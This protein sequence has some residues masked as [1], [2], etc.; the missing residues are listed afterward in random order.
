VDATLNKVPPLSL[1]RF[2]YAMTCAAVTATALAVLLVDARLAILP[3]AL[4]FG[5]SQI[6]SA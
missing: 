2:T 1:R 3:A 6:G 4:I 5:W